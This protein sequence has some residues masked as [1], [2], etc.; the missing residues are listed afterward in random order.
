MNTNELTALINQTTDSILDEWAAE[1]A[2]VGVN[3]DDYIGD[4]LDEMNLDETND[5][6]S[7]AIGKRF[8]QRLMGVAA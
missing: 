8:V 4:K 3:A 2:Q 5:E 1:A 7:I 6:A